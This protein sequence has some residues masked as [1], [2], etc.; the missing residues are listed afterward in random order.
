MTF[1]DKL[2]AVRKK[3]FLSQQALGTELGVDR[4]TVN[5]WEKGLFEPNYT[6][7]KAFHELCVKNNIQFKENE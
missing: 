6:A 3:L 1:G 4:S 5:R 2:K 7:Q